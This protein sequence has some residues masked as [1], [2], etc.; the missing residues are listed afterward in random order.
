MIAHRFD[1]EQSHP[2][3][4]AIQLLHANAIDYSNIPYSEPHCHIFTEL[5][6]VL[7]GNGSF[8]IENE[9]IPVQ[10]NDLI[11]VNPQVMHQGLRADKNGLFVL[12]LGLCCPYLFSSSNDRYILLSGEENQSQFR[13][14]M[15]QILR[16]IK[17]RSPGFEILCQKFS[18][19]IMLH[20]GR[21][22]Q[23]S[24]VSAASRKSSRECA[25]VRLYIEEH[26]T[27]PLTLD[28]LAEYANLNK[29][30]LVHVFNRQMGCS[31]ISYLIERRISESKQ[32]LASSNVP[33]RQ[34]SEQL[35]FSSPSY[36]SQSFRHATG[37]SPAKYRRQAQQC[38]CMDL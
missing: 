23:Y 9:S 3:S 28:H 22:C 29:Y 35:G 2:R 32:M 21:R 10:T 37:L 18:D 12:S 31:P 16:E 14:Y 26:F 15:E 6:F 1:T 20:L 8:R 33:I 13:L 30:Y 4:P 36:F 34:I 38:V 25:R 11:L 17:A 7:Q 19:V 24:K 27:E 5:M